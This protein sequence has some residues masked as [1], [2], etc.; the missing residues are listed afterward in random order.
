VSA[1]RSGKGDLR[2]TE[3]SVEGLLERVKGVVPLIAER[4]ADA[5]LKRKPDDEVIDA[6]KATGVFRSFV[7]KTYGGY[8]IGMDLY[9]DIGIVVSEACASTGWITTFYMEHNWLLGL[10]DEALQ[11]EIFTSAPFILAPGSVNPRGGM[12]RI[13]DGGYELTG[14]WKFATG[15]V[16]ADWVLLSTM[17]ETDDE[18]VQRL[19]IVRPADITVEDTWHVDGMAATGSRDIVADRVFVPDRQVSLLVPPVVT[20]GADATYLMRLPVR[21]F[22]SLT[23][24]IPAV[25]AARRAVSL[26]RELLGERVRFGTK[27]V[28]KESASAQ[29]RLAN[30]LTEVRAVETVLRAAAQTIDRH[31]RGEIRL[32]GM[33]QQELG[34]AIAHVV[35]DCAAVVRQVMQG[36]GASVHFLD[37]PLQRINRDVQMMSAHTVF[38]VDLSAEQCGRARLESEAPLFSRP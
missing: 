32:S 38:D 14:R 37:H 5:E 18:P 3:V 8:E 6:L 16:H 31:A 2:V 21:P 33:E 24:A 36:S 19:C 4:A 23:A 30:S 26:Y 10:F 35:R 9:M 13:V 7:P 27:K 22:L 15:V 34:L 29:I 20:A 25:G 12:A 11:H 28:Q 17:V 1:T